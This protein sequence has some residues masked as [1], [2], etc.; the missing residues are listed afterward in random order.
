VLAP[1]LAHNL[2]T[3]MSGFAMLA[4]SWTP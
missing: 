3:T 2:D 1:N 4:G